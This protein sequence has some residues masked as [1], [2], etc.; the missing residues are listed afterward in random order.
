MGKEFKNKIDFCVD[1]EIL[2]F[3]IDFVFVDSE[4]FLIFVFIMVGFV[5]I[6]FGEYYCM[7]MKFCI[8]FCLFM[9][10]W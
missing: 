3:V 10:Y 5:L 8:M 6:F 9:L 7:K 2:F 4:M 1:V